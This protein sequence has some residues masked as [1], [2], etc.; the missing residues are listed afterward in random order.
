MSFEI[1]ALGLGIGVCHGCYPLT[2]LPV[3]SETL[4]YRITKYKQ[5]SK[6]KIQLLQIIK[7]QTKSNEPMRW[8]SL[9]RIDCKRLGL[10]QDI[11]HRD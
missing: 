7:I 8:G 11:W 5:E 6:N 2:L 4:G 1:N 9:S 3:K 10:G